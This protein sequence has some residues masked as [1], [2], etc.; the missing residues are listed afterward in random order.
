MGIT[1]AVRRLAL[2]PFGELPK[3][4][5]VE[6]VELDGVTVGFNRWPSAQIVRIVD[7]DADIPAAVAATRAAARERG[8]EILGWWI[9]P[10]RAEFAPALEAAGL[11]NED[12]PGFEATE[13]AM[14]LVEP[15]PRGSA[16][17]VEI[18]VVDTWEQSEETGRVVRS[19]FG[20]PESSEEQ[21]RAGFDDYMAGRDKGSGLYAAIDG[22]IVGSG[23]AAF[24]AAGINLFGACV[25]PEAR[26]RG[27]YRSLV[28]ARWEMAVERGT[29][30]LTVQ[31][32]KM[33]RPILERVGFQFIAAARVFV[34]KLS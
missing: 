33:S 3:P 9:P 8:K 19:V 26:G 34:D 15:P 20:M 4:N 27:V 23:Y 24:G 31:A 16:P 2:D 22:R 14:A 10:D 17:D 12:T 7:T 13:N 25:L 6:L 11:V 30:A 21:R 18:G 5:D 32:G 1:E 28:A 29:P